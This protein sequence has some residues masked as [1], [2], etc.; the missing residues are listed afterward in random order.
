MR[1]ETDDSLLNSINSIKLNES[2]QRIPSNGEMPTIGVQRQSNAVKG[3]NKA[4]LPTS[5]KGH[6]TTRGAGLRQIGNMIT[7]N[8]P[9]SIYQAALTEIALN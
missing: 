2:Q 1:Q 4:P 3:Q 6:S 8:T 7:Q 5:K 9:S